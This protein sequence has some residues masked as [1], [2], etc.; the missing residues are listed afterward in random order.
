MV[1]TPQVLK[2][3]RALS[4]LCWAGRWIAPSSKFV[5]AITRELYIFIKGV[6]IE[7]YTYIFFL[8]I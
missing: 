3:D 8:L 7:R 6:F 4:S 1:S 2:A 5:N